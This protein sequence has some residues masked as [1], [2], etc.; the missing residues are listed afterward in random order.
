MVNLVSEA[1][2]AR[3]GDGRSLGYA[4]YGQPEGRPV[5]YFT[6]GNSSRLEGRWFDRN[7]RDRGICLIV[8]DRPGFGLSD[9]QSNRRLL[10]WPRDIAEL[11]KALG[12]GEFAVFGLSGG[13]PH[14]AAVL[15]SMPAQVPRGAIVS[16]LAPP[17]MPARYRGMW[18]PLRLLFLLAKYTPSLNRAALKQMGNFYANPIQMKKQMMRALPEPDRNLIQTQPEVIDA[19]SAAAREAHRNGIDGDSW[20]WQLYVRPWGFEMEAILQP[21]GLWYGELDRNAPVGMGR[22]LSQRLPHAR[23]KVV[24]D[25]GHFSTI[26][27]HIDEIFDYLLTTNGQAREA[28]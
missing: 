1:E 27:N 21:V 4:I 7:A 6:G 14:V 26:N 3:L 16:G 12:V 19:F 18:L 17:E 20:E 15:H 2:V 5:L 8:P 23:L 11:V 9:F 13:G 24:P 25:G 22:Y 28:A 10:D